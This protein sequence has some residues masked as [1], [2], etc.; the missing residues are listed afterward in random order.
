M[1][2]DGGVMLIGNSWQA[3]GMQMVSSLPT[4]TLYAKHNWREL[5]RNICI[6]I[7]HIGTKE[8]QLYGYSLLELGIDS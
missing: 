7:I 3:H 6:F 4:M 8:C 1:E 5:Y 2:G